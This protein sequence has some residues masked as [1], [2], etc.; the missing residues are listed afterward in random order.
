MLD[1]C[2]IY[3]LKENNSFVTLSKIGYQREDAYVR[4]IIFTG[5]TRAKMRESGDAL[6]NWFY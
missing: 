4:N 1:L 5:K 3:C 6:R 2:T